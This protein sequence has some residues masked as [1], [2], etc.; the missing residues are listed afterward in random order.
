MLFGEVG[1]RLG[2]EAGGMGMSTGLSLKG[3]QRLWFLGFTRH[4]RHET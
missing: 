4:V 2:G 1:I 3:S